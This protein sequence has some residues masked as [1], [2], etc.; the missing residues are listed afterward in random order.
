MFVP[1]I[2]MKLVVFIKIF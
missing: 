2:L 1:K